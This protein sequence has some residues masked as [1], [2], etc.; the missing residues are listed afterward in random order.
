MQK[1]RGLEAYGSYETKCSIK[2]GKIKIQL[3]IIKDFVL[4]TKDG[5][6]KE[7]KVISLICP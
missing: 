6:I 3:K 2:I 4:K 1:L 7:I 5:F